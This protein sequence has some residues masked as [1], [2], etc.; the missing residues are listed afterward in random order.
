MNSLTRKSYILPLLIVSQFACTS[1]WFAGN[2]IVD[3]LALKTGLGNSIIGYVLSSVQLGFILGT[4]VFAL[5]MIADR[6][7]PSKVFAICAL[8]AALCNFSLLADTITKWHILGARFGTGFFLAGIYPVGMKIASDYYKNGLGKALGYLVGALVLGTAFPFLI[9][10][11]NWGSNYQTILQATSIL[12][13]LGGLVVVIFVPN[14]PYRKQS[15]KLKLKAGVQLF[16]NPI[17]TK[18]AIGYFGHMWELYAFWAFTPLAIKTINN[19]QNTNYSVPIFTFMVIA[20]GA[21]SCAVGGSFSKKH[22][23][24]KVAVIALFISGL[25]CFLSP[26]FFKLPALFFIISWCIW[27]MAVTADSPQFSSLVAQAAPTELK[28]TGLTL[29]N[30]IGFAISILSIQLLAA[31]A[32][33]INASFIFLFL[34]IGPLIGL[35]AL[36][37]KK[38]N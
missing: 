19:I 23:S 15:S 5:L 2:A 11:L 8:F 7:S 3:D 12:A 38:Y 28:G 32:T 4:L 34:G 9:S 24:Y 33:S 14:G 26:L 30:S 31:L 20:L 27:G 21:V 18:A 37:K 22:G 17:F 10:G 1:L 35:F 36:L 6:F 29:V 13:L 16:K 25:C